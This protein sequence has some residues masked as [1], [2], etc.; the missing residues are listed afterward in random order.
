M[1]KPSYVARFLKKRKD[2]ERGATSEGLQGGTPKEII[3]I[4][5]GNPLLGESKEKNGLF[6]LYSK[7][8]SEEGLAEYVLL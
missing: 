8:E 1:W 3:D 4:A 5:R 2:A 6:M 7:P